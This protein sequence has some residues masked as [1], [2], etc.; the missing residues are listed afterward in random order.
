MLVLSPLAQLMAQTHRAEEELLDCRK[1]LTRSRRQV[2]KLQTELE[3]ERERCLWLSEEA[4]VALEAQLQQHDHHQQR[5]PC[6]AD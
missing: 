3:F 1:E 4:A 6:Q 2:K 5:R